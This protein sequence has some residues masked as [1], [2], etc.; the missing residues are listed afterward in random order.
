[1]P[2]PLLPPVDPVVATPV[3]PRTA[4]RARHRRRHRWLAWS[5]AAVAVLVLAAAGWVAAQRIGRPSPPTTVTAAAH[6]SLTVPGSAPSLPW[7]ILGQGAVSVPALGYSAQSGP[8]SSVPI[9][10]LTKMTNAVV[11]LRDHP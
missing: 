5:S 9:A 8:E 11:I 2:P 3:L 10:S 6:P 4:R 7:P 1:P